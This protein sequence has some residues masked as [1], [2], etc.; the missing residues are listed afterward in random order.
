[1]I[2]LWLPKSSRNGRGGV[3]LGPRPH[4]QLPLPA[5]AVSWQVASACH[6]LACQQPTKKKW[7]QELGAIR[8]GA[9][10][11]AAAAKVLLP[12]AISPPPPRTLPRPILAQAKR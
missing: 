6:L 11:G 1:M 2:K 7:G 5:P 9:K 3:S 4:D 8:V 12:L 10:A